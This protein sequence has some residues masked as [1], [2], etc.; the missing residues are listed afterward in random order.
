MTRVPYFY[1]TN[2]LL[3]G[4]AKQLRVEHPRSKF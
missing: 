1:E 2:I 4:A 3:Y